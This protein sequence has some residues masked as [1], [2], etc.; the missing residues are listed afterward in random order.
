M[1]L[2]KLIDTDGHISYI[3]VE[4]IEV[5]EAEPTTGF[6]VARYTHTAKEISM[7]FVKK[8][9]VKGRGEPLVKETLETIEVKAGMIVCIVEDNESYMVVPDNTPKAKKGK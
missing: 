9:I 7:T 1:F 8:E 6:V 3:S 4:D 5:E 2:V